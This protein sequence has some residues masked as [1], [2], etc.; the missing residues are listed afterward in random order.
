MRPRR[1]VLIL[2]IG[3]ILSIVTA[4]YLGLFNK[5]SQNDISHLAPRKIRV[6]GIIVGQPKKRDKRTV[7]VLKV[8]EIVNE[9]YMSRRDTNGNEKAP[10]MSLPDSRS[11]RGQAPILQS[12]WRMQ[13]RM[14]YPVKP[15]SD[16]GGFSGEKRNISGRVLVNCYSPGFDFKRGNEIE[17]KGYLFCPS[18][19][20]N[21]GEF[22]YRKYLS[23]KKIYALLKINS[24]KNIKLISGGGR[25]FLS[26]LLCLLRQGM[27]KKIEKS[28][29]KTSSWQVLSGI[30][31][32]ERAVLPWEV[33]ENFIKS[34]IVHTLAVSGLHVGLV[35][36]I[37]LGFFQLINLHRK[38][39][40]I[41][42]IIAIF[43]YVQVTGAYPSAIRAFLMASMG[44]LGYLFG[45]DRNLRHSLFLSALIILL[46][47][48]R[49]LFNIGFQFSFLATIGLLYLSGSIRKGLA[50][51][52]KYL[53][54]ALSIS[55]GAQIMISP[56][57]AYYF[58]QISLIA[59][60]ANLF[61]VP[62]I[63][64]IV[65]F[66]FVTCLISLISGFLTS[67][68][69]KINGL[70]ID[71]LLKEAEFFASFPFSSLKVIT[72]SFL[73]LAGF[74]LVIL[75]LINYKTI[76]NNILKKVSPFK[77]KLIL[78]LTGIIF[79]FTFIANSFFISNDLKITFLALRYGDS[80]FVEFPDGSNMLIDTG[81]VVRQ[82]FNVG[83]KI[84]APFLLS[85][86]VKKID[87]IVLTRDHFT[88][89]GGLSY[90][91]R[92]FK[93]KEVIFNSK[94]YPFDKPFKLRK[95]KSGDWIKKE[96]G[97]SIQVLNPMSKIKN[98]NNS[99]TLHLIYG[100]FSILFTGD[101]GK[102]AQKRII[103]ECNV[104]SKIL[105]IP[106]QG[107]K[108]ILEKFLWE[109]SPECVII[110]TLTKPTKNLI[111]QLDR[112]RLKK[113]KNLEIY[114]TKE[115]GALEITTCGKGY[116]IRGY[117]DIKKR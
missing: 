84:I 75:F 16:K 71:F 104:K 29:K 20:L 88:H 52:P 4:D 86:G 67:V 12:S 113:E 49:D 27:I 90:I 103:N 117:K 85:K 7:F 78:S 74:Y 72:P 93:V 5:I 48:P 35:L 22:D 31:L 116:E 114:T 61:V 3:Y 101:I 57:V 96:S 26:G 94:I 47:N 109:I 51:L 9:T 33:Y 81:K 38:F 40:Y 23:R 19:P 91:L 115:M 106:Y 43:L 69:G 77:I 110:T 73:F 76:K 58:N 25:N 65:T 82:R 98:R 13:S 46:I 45:R 15:D 112:R 41:L 44:L 8:K 64:I 105:Q 28:L 89:T 59:P 42:T 66:G 108:G 30:M 37:F 68:I 56:L 34:G 39:A 60:L 100:D 2:T 107:K 17:I 24:R 36:F 11:S 50:F 95:I 55:L 1:I 80:I 32:G 87:T 14:D 99:L 79:C 102:R 83:E 21:P 70:C 10:L 97:F 62:L 54:G 53:Q 63:G 6:R 111:K 18:S 92:N